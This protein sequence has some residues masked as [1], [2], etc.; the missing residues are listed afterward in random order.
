MLLASVLPERNIHLVERSKEK[1]L[2]S[3]SSLPGR[4]YYITD[5]LMCQEG[6]IYDYLPENIHHDSDRLHVYFIP[7]FKKQWLT[8]GQ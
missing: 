6:L 3:V 1:G 7:S 2:F 5:S 8:D 4:R